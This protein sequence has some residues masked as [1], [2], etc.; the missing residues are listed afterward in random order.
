MKFCILMGSPRINKNTAE[1]CKPFIE[2]LKNN[3]A[4]VTYITLA[5]KKISSCKGCYIC[6][7]V[8]DEYGCFQSDDMDNII[9]EIIASDYLI[10]A[11]PI[12]S[13]YC[14][15][16][17]KLVLDRLYGMNKFYGKGQGTLWGNQN[18]AIIATH[19]YDRKYAFDP[20]EMGIK[21]LCE[22]SKINYRGAY[23]V[24]D[25]DN[26]NSFKTEDAIE[27]SR[28]FALKLLSYNKLN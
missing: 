25:I 5:D 21:R 27:G 4:D 9:K 12:Y 7:N 16:E 11:T 20:F 1:L 23:S 8:S 10:L 15:T 13:W 22:H 19:G 14:P 3:K 18:V 2:E 6:Q 24:R 17:M 28:K 26:V